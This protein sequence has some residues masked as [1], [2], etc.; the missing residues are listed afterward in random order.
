MGFG[1]GRRERWGRVGLVVVRRWQIGGFDDGRRE[2][3]PCDSLDG[4]R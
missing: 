3:L 2:R 4:G 1:D